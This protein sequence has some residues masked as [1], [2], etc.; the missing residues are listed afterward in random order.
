MPVLI[1]AQY[2]RKRSFAAR[3]LCHLANYLLC[4]STLLLHIRSCTAEA[5]RRLAICWGCRCSRSPAADVP[6][7]RCGAA[8]V[9]SVAEYVT[10]SNDDD[11]IAEALERWVL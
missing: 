1:L 7:S 10:S 9:L 3:L 5:E 6:Y 11:G 4:Y 8:Q 2:A